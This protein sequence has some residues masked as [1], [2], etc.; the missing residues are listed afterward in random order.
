MKRFLATTAIALVISNGAFAESH[1]AADG[2]ATDS[3]MTTETAPATDPATST[4]TMAPAA[5]STTATEPATM[6]DTTATEMSDPTAATDSTSTTMETTGTTDMAM[7]PTMTIDGYE[8]LMNADVTAEM[9]TGAAIY[10]PNDDKVGEIGDLVI[11]D[12]S[13]ITD[14]IV[15]VGGFLGLGEKPVS[16]A[17]DSVQILKE[18]DGDDLR[19]YVGMTEDQ[20]KELPRYEAM[21]DSADM[22][23]TDATVT[24]AP[25]ADAP[26]ADAP[27]AD[28]PAAD[29]PAEEM[30]AEEAP[31]N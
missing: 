20:L 22:P 30:P 18:T 2:T 7:A 31:A 3:T 1:V 12:D 28:A 5:D 6:G 24:D 8:T 4:D 11:G 17:Y 13:T 21:D 25:A 9:L 29:A 16:I 27:A 26:V 15:D 10:G 23:A 19:A 14:I